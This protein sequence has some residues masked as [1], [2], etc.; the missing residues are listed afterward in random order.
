MKIVLR[1][2]EYSLAAGAMCFTVIVLM[3]NG[4]QISES[5]KGGGHGGG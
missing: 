2:L 5:E 4:A 3:S 1:A